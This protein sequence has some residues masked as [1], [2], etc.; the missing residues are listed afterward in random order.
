MF[1]KKKMV[2]NMG[3]KELTDTIISAVF[4]AVT[5]LEQKQMESLKRSL[6]F[7]VQTAVVEAIK[8]YQFV[9][10]SSQKGN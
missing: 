5:T 8:A 9:E 7:S 3:K 6:K 2:A 4:A 10:N 1:R